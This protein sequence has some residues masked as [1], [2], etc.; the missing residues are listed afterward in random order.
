MGH[1]AFRDAPTK[2][3]G[4]QLSGE[5]L[6]E[7]GVSRNRLRKPVQPHEGHT[8][9]VGFRS[10]ER[11][12]GVD[13][14]PILVGRAVQPDGV[15]LLECQTICVEEC[16]TGGAARVLAMLFEGLANVELR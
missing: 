2:T 8:R 6:A 16:M 10:R 12:R 9:G 5:T 11:Y 3:V 4:E 13:R 15:V 14:R 1:V 7:M